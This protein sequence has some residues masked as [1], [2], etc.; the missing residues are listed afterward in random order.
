ML[1]LLLSMMLYQAPVE[2]ERQ[3]VFIMDTAYPRNKIE[4]SSSVTT[5]EKNYRSF[6]YDLVDGKKLKIEFFVCTH[7]TMS[8]EYFLP[9]STISK[10]D[11]SLKKEVHNFGEMVLDDWDF[12]DYKTE[13]EKFDFASNLKFKKIPSKIYQDFY[14][15]ISQKENG[16]LLTI[17]NMMN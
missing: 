11:F 4:A 12:K 2:Q 15:D 14:L 7:F 1:S 13:I 3:C 10:D 5:E 16:T 17:V 8:A 9:N 6:E